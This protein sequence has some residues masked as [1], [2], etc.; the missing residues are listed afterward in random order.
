MV[1]A[2]PDRDKTPENIENCGGGENGVSALTGSAW[3]SC[4]E[5]ICYL[6]ELKSGATIS[7]DVAGRWLRDNSLSKLTGGFSETSVE[8]LRNAIADAWDQGGSYDQIIKAVQE[9][10]EQFSSVRAGMIAQTESADAYNEGRWVM[11]AEMGMEEK[12]WE[13]ESGTPCDECLANEAQGYI[14][15]DEDF[16]SGDDAPTLHPNCLCILNFRKG[17]VE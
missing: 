8:R 7:E 15:M 2:R 4:L 14:G 12:A 9:T 13:T 5:R 10:F 17:H 3:L 1:Y 6:A 16:Q 11:A